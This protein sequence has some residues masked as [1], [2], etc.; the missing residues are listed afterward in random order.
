MRRWWQG[1]QER[2]RRIMMLGAFALMVVLGYGLIW[3]PL[4]EAREQA[5]KDLARSESTL[6]WTR[7]AAAQIISL[8]G[9]GRAEPDN[10]PLLSIVDSTAKRSGL[11]DGIRRIQPIG[12]SD[13]R[14]SLDGASYRAL[15]AWLAQL[16]G[17][18]V[19]AV[20]LSLQRENDPGK[21]T[22]NLTLHRDG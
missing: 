12:Q 5:R 3:L 11:Q 20:E 1:L 17:K 18:G 21:V 14:V 13:V 9:S 16:H 8:R 10:R 22:A 15:V 7:Q 2:E 19:K 6:T 4:Q